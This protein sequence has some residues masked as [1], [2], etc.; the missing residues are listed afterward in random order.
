MLRLSSLSLLILCTQVFADFSYFTYSDNWSFYSPEHPNQY[1]V[2]PTGVLGA[3]AFAVIN[4]DGNLDVRYPIAPATVS[5]AQ[6]SNPAASY[7][8]AIGGWNNSNLDPTGAQNMGL[9]NVLTN[10]QNSYIDPNTGLTGPQRLMIN[11]LY[12]ATLQKGASWS[13]GDLPYP[14]G[15][16]PQL[17]PQLLPKGLGYSCLI[18]DF[19]D[20]AK[21]P[22]RVQNPNMF[23]LVMKTIVE[24]LPHVNVQMAIP[25]FMEN[26]GYMDLDD[27]MANTHINFQLMTYDYAAGLSPVV[28]TSNASIDVTQNALAAYAQKYPSQMNRFLVGIPCYGRGFV[29]DRNL[30]SATIEQG[31]KN[32]TLTGSYL[33]NNGDSIVSADDIL[34]E[35]GSWD[36][37]TNG[38][39]LIP[40]LNGN[41]NDYFYYQ[42]ST[43][44]IISAFPNGSTVSSVAD[45]AKMIKA[46]SKD[47]GDF[48]GFM[49]WEAQQDFQGTIIQSLKS[50]MSE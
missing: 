17:Y 42:S 8:L 14:S 13:D 27:L 6:G 50:Y 20:Y 40:V 22:G 1:P 33:D 31:V 26:Q 12:V 11:N 5:W 43:G 29:I 35:I 38:W 48:A 10:N 19:E 3:T 15:G 32:G 47:H 16:D 36:S 25:G 44:I 24:K 18:M 49:D 9:Y 23:N 39:T 46:F 2:I 45:F 21:V 4:D 34:K 28:V 30:S 7:A 37:P 41:Y